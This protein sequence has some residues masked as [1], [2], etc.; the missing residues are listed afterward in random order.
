MIR[1]ADE[2]IDALG[3][4][5]LQEWLGVEAS[6]VSSWKTRGIAPAWHLR[7]F[8]ELKRRR[9]RFDCEQLFGINEDQARI[10][11]DLRIVPPPMRRV[12]SVGSPAA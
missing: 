2:L 1:N 12:G 4:A 7:L 3:H 11:E 9:L 6:T 8:L 5:F 10:V